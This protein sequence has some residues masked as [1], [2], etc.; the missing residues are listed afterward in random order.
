[1]DLRE[2]RQQFRTMDSTHARE[3]IDEIIGVYK[4]EVARK[5]TVAAMAFDVGDMVTFKGRGRDIWTGKVTK[6]NRTTVT[7]WATV[8]NSLFG[9]IPER[10]M[11]WRVHP[12]SL[13]K[14]Q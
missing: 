14:V 4:E 7:V 5:N 11:T 9:S 6:V 3:L 2:L 1:M 13:T 12:T 10:A 8:S